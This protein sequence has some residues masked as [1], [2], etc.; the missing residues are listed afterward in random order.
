MSQPPAPIFN[1]NAVPKQQRLDGSVR[2]DGEIQVRNELI[3][4]NQ[5]LRTEFFVSKPDVA[6]RVMN[7]FTSSGVLNIVA[8]QEITGSLPAKLSGKNGFSGLAGEI[9]F[10]CNAITTVDTAGGTLDGNVELKLEGLNVAF[11]ENF[12]KHVLE[13]NDN[14]SVFSNLKGTDFISVPVEKKHPVQGT[15]DFPWICRRHS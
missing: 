4:Y 9:R 6:G 3:G 13:V 8:N 5:D 14:P 1:F 12:F 2:V 11:D 10:L 15:E 7:T